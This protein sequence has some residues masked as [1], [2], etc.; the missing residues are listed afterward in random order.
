MRRETLKLH[1][2]ATMHVIN[3]EIADSPQEK[4]QGLMFRTSLA[5]DQGRGRTAGAHASGWAVRRDM[6]TMIVVNAG[7]MRV[8]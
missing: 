8:N 3:V 4:A 1:T 7:S 2:A 5:D 6:L